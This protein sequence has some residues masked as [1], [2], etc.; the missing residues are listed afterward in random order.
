MRWPELLSITRS[1]R[2]AWCRTLGLGDVTPTLLKAA[3]HTSVLIRSL[4]IVARVRSSEPLATAKCTATREIAV[5]RHLADRHAPALAPLNGIA[6][7]PHLAGSSVVTLWPYIEHARIA[8]ETDLLSAAASLASLHDG[9]RDYDGDLPPYTDA[10]DRCWD[11]LMREDSTA[12]VRQDRDLLVAQYRRLRRDLE[13]ISRPCVPIHGDAHLGNLLFG[14]RGPVWVDFEEACL[15]PR[16]Y[17][18]ANLPPTAWPSVTNVDLSLI[19]RLADLK[20]VCVAVW[21]S[22][23]I[24]RSSEIRDAANYH[25][26]RVR[27]FAL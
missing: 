5:A 8:D 1:R 3:H 19:G 12:L 14:N 23:D 13:A 20:S 21:C 24:G 27:A 16:E 26:Q 11:V 10:L 9:L 7:G 6:A 18:V 4:G 17:D 22:A 15:E 25:L 2:S